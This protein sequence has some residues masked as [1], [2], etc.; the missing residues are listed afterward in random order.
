MLGKIPQE[1]PD[2]LKGPNTSLQKVFWGGFGGFWTA[3]QEVR[4]GP[5]GSH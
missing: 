1:I 4:T 2:H 3:S 5:L